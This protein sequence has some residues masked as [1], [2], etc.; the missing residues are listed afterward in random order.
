MENQESWFSQV[1]SNI[2]ENREKIYYRDYRFFQVDRFL[3]LAGKVD[4]HSSS[5]RECNS[6]KRDI[7]EVADNLTDY[8]SGSSKMRRKY[9]SELSRMLEHMRY[10]HGFYP[11]E[12]YSSTYSAWGLVIGL[13]LGYGISYLISPESWLYGISVGGMSCVLIARQFGKKKDKVI[14]AADLIL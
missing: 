8:L 11:L 13:V 14:K 6:M 4:N 5:C 12:Y 10:E 2:F 1:E 7:S 3:K 9:E